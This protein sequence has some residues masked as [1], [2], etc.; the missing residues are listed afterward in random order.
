MVIT[1]SSGKH[2][3]PVKHPYMSSYQP[4]FSSEI[5]HCHIWFPKEPKKNQSISK[6]MI[7]PCSNKTS[8]NWNV[9]QF[10][11]ELTWMGT[12]QHEEYS[13]RIVPRA[14]QIFAESVAG[15]GQ[16]HENP[17]C[18]WSNFPGEIA[19]FAQLKTEISHFSYADTLFFPKTYPIFVF[20]PRC[21]HVFRLEDPWC[22]VTSSIRL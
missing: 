15:S 14:P 8:E 18:W 17:W 16:D 19:Y 5:F 13:N 9:I 10:R 1:H 11:T 7:Q 6:Q 12:N 4:Q 22:P 2:M 20:F 3:D 21:P